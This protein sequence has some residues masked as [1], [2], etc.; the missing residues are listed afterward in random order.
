MANDNNDNDSSNKPVADLVAI[1]QEPDGRGGQRDVF[2]KL[3]P[4]W[5]AR[6]ES[7]NYSGTLSLE[8][9]QW[10]NVNN[11]RRIIVQMRRAN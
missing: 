6:G 3:C 11:A 9:I 2:V 4:L 5:M 8:P 7:G 10:R 1:V